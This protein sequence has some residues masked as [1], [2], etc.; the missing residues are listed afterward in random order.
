[1]FADTH[2]NDFRSCWWIVPLA[3]IGMGL[4]IVLWMIEV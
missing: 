1:M 3:I 2:S 4:W